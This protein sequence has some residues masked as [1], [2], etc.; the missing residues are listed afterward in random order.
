MAEDLGAKSRV[1]NTFHC[2]AA[3]P[4]PACPSFPAFPACPACP[5]FPSCPGAPDPVCPVCPGFVACPAAASTSPLV[6]LAALWADIL[7]FLGPSLFTEQ[8]RAFWVALWAFLCNR[9]PPWWAFVSCWIS[10]SGWVSTWVLAP[11]LAVC[12][13]I[14]RLCCCLC[15]CGCGRHADNGNDNNNDNHNNDR[16]DNDLK[17]GSV[18]AEVMR[19]STRRINPPPGSG[20]GSGVE[21]NPN[22]LTQTRTAVSSS[23]ALADSASTYVSARGLKATVL[24]ARGRRAHT[25]AFELTQ[26]LTHELTHTDVRG[27]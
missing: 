9:L 20:S 1:E 16:Q 8:G 5:A 11:F 24:P 3:Q 4:P 6:L 23:V 15:P 2:Q 7:V 10:V 25:W 17:R 26:I 19:E 12:R 27:V 22:P 21:P 18:I 13:F 14:G